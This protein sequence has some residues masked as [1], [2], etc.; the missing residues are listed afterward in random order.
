[1][2]G[3]VP[4]A[5]SEALHN[6]DCCAGLFCGTR[7]DCERIFSCLGYSGMPARFQDENMQL[8]AMNNLPPDRPKQAGNGQSAPLC[9]FCQRSGISTWCMKWCITLEVFAEIEQ[10]RGFLAIIRRLV[11]PSNCRA[12]PLVQNFAH[13]YLP[14]SRAKNP[15]RGLGPGGSMRDVCSCQWRACS[16]QSSRS[17]FN[18]SIRGAMGVNSSF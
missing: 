9:I 13:I 2:A 16:F 1:V 12:F 8:G 14:N 15:G 3:T 5:H 4:L 7:M 11:S 10:W 17:C 6:S 18:S